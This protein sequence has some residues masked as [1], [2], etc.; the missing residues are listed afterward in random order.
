MSAPDR[1]RLVDRGD[2]ELSIRRQCRLLN[3]ARSGLY[4]LPTPANDDELV[5][6]RRIDE[7]FTAWPF[8]GSR[9]MACDAARRRLLHQPQAGAAADAASGDRR[10]GAEAED[11]G[12]RAPGT[13]SSR[14]AARDDHRQTQP[15]V[16]GG[17][18]LHLDRPRLPLSRGD[19]RL[20][21]PGGP[22]LAAV[23]H[24]GR[25]VLHLGA[26]R[27]TGALRQ[28]PHLQHRPGEPWAPRSLWCTKPAPRIG[29][30]SCSACSRASSTKPACAVL[31]TRQPTMRRT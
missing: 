25:V 8:L 17:H 4:R 27:G 31:D 3:V 16:G 24:H 29:R 19:H 26:G 12:S 1:R 10:V 11:D 2:D 13:K 15:G 6:M 5:P 23:E 30:R 18:H 22:G 9:R 14:F 21:Q 7:L 28:A 20:G